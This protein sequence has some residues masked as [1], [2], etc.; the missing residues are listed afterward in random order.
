MNDFNKPT[1][2]SI[3]NFGVTVS[4]NFDHS[5]VTIGQMFDAFKA[6]MV[7]IT[8]SEEQIREH[9]IQLAYE[10]ENMTDN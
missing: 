6:A 2:L 7:G 3:T 9:V 4:V 5:D 10:W 1:T 8:F